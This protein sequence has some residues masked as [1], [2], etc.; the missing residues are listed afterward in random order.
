MQGIIEDGRYRI[1]EVLRSGEGYEACLCND[2][3]R[4]DDYAPLLFN[5]YS[6][7][8]EIKLFLPLYYAMK[9]SGYRDF[10]RLVTSDGNVCA[11]FTYH[12]GER[13]ST[14]FARHP[15]EKFEE[16]LIYADRLLSAA[17]ETDMLDG[18]IVCGALSEEN[19]VVDEKDL[20]VYFNVIAP[21]QAVRENGFR[22][23]RLGRMLAMIFPPDRYLPAEITDF[24]E[25]LTSFDDNDA[26]CVEIYS[27]WR[28]VCEQA[29]ETRRLYEKESLTQ[30]LSRKA[31][32]KKRRLQKKKNEQ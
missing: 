31:K 10:V 27:M 11:V 2:V 15:N 1:I 26:D 21:P 29:R 28:R 5:V 13:F 14:F 20:S 24:I 32:E 17:L 7:K 8:N 16:K 3:T 30:Y 25:S 4:N 6:R 22:A 23:K 18:A 12:P 9:D 19:A